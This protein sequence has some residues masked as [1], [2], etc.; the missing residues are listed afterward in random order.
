MKTWFQQSNKF[1]IITK[2]TNSILGLITLLVYALL[3]IFGLFWFNNQSSFLCAQ[4]LVF[5]TLD[6]SPTLNTNGWDLNGNAFVGNTNGTANNDPDELILTTNIMSQMGSVFWNQPL[7]LSVCSKWTVEFDFRMFDGDAADGIAFCF[8]DVPPSGFING[9]GVGIPNTAN[10]LKVVLDSFDNGCGP[11]PEIQIYSGVGYNECAPGIIKAVNT[12]GVLDFVRNTNY[13]RCIINYDAGQVTVSINGT[14]YLS[15][16]A[17]IN[18]TGYFGFTASTGYYHDIHSIKNVI[19]Y[20]DQPEADAGLDVLMCSGDEAVL[21]TTS[22]PGYS[23]AWTPTTG[24]SD[25]TISNPAV[26]LSNNGVLPISLVFVVQT[27]LD[28][29]PSCPSFDTVTVTIHPN[30]QVFDSVTSC[31]SYTWPLNGVTYFQ[32]GQYSDTIVSA[33]GCDSIAILSLSITDQYFA[34]ESTTACDTYYW[35]TNG[36]TYNQSGNY[37]HIVSNSLGCDSIFELNLTI[38]SSIH[39][40]EIIR[41]CDPQ[42]QDVLIFEYT[43]LNG[44]DSIH[45]IIYALYDPS[46]LPLASFYTSPSTTVMLPSG[47]IQ[48]FNTSLNATSFLWDFGDGSGLFSETN[49]SHSYD[50]EGEYVITLIANNSTNCPDT[51]YVLI[52]VHEELLIYVPNTFTPD[53][54]QYNNV[55]QPVFTSGF[56]P[57]DYHLTIFNRWGETLFESHNDK[58]GWDGTYGGRMAKEG[59]YLWKIEFAVKHTD[60]RKLFT[61]HVT[62]LK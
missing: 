21:G 37:S 12:G 52:A 58:E 29:N 36:T 23:Y 57:N 49:P 61:G 4:S 48:T 18:F 40:Q 45:T 31:H 3:P 50:N 19:I 46:Q 27:T 62:V 26:S 28:D 11:N 43:T 17:P 7:D 13:Q 59:T 42:N 35:L 33:A 56:D 14:N 47:F 51:S 16:F 53:G 1:K 2:L 20:T 8:I 30:I 54:D 6:G 15:G 38:H 25:P 39:S 24:L 9:G 44:C 34:N 22:N 55:F 10:G 5:A 41:V 32:S 60:E